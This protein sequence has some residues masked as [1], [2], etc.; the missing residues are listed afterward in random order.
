MVD[1]AQPSGF[2]RRTELRPRRVIFCRPNLAKGSVDRRMVAVMDLQ[3][4]GDQLGRCEEPKRRQK[5]LHQ[6]V[7][8]VYLI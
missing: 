4:C 7:R 8:V 1:K 6:R 2:C 3:G 5:I